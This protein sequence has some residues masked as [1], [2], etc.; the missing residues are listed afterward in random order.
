[1]LLRRMA[2]FHPEMVADA[3]AALG[4]DHGQYMDAHNRWQSMLR[5]RRSPQGLDLYTA[6]LGP[7][8]SERPTPFGDVTLTACRWRL[9][10]LWPDLRYE[11]MIGVN[12]VVLH[13]WLVRASESDAPPLAD[14]YGIAPWSCVVGD[15]LARYPDAE[16]SDRQVPSQWQVHVGGRRLV[17]VHGLVQ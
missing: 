13:G 3:H 16:Q 8:D 12:G 6:V 10:D 15:V 17:F 11:T 7:P 4:A 9:T 5:S 1:M 2:D 14:V